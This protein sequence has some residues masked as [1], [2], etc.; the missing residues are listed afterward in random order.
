MKYIAINLTDA[1]ILPAI[2]KLLNLG[3]VFTSPTVREL[4][5]IT[6][7][8]QIVKQLKIQS[9]YGVSILLGQYACMMEWEMGACVYVT[10]NNFK[11]MTVDEFVENYRN[12]EPLSYCN[13]YK[14]VQETPRAE[15]ID[16]VDGTPAFTTRR[17]RTAY[18]TRAIDREIDP[19]NH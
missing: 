16:G 2:G 14:K 13:K 3:Y 8:D 5:R 11:V 15:I 10:D 17:W 9:Y 18:G 6:N 1:E 4:K 7:V 19:T 12:F